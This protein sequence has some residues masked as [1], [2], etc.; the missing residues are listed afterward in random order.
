MNTELYKYDNLIEDIDLVKRPSKTIKSP[1]IADILVNNKEE[2]AHCPALGVSGL[3]NN[4]LAISSILIL[5]G[6]GVE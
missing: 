6:S 2:Y 4:S 3:L 1:Y 5:I